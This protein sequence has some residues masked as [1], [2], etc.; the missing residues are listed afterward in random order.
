MDHDWAVIRSCSSLVEAGF[1][2]SLLEPEGI[3]VQIPDEYAVGVNPGYTNMLGGI[4]VM[5]HADQLVRAN[6]VLETSAPAAAL[7]D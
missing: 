1:L 5:V 4:R 6:E 7:G 3:D 2:K